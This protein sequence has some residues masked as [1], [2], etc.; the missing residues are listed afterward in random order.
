[1]MIADQTLIN[2]PFT[3]PA[4]FHVPLL[5]TIIITTM[6]MN[7]NTHDQLIYPVPGPVGRH[8]DQKQ[9]VLTCIQR[10]LQLSL[11]MWFILTLT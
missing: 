5:I 6:H 2:W 10:D 7:L 11:L 3:P 9:S 1:M 8:D 4:R